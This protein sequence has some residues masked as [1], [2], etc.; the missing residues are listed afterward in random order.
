VCFASFLSGEYTTMVVI[1][2]PEKKLAKRTSVH[3]LFINSTNAELGNVNCRAGTYEMACTPESQKKKVN[4][5]GIK[6][7]QN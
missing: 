1:N 4:G 7:D 2:P 3:W 5:P 6:L